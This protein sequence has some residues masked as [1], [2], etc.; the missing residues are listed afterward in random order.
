MRTFAFAALATLAATAALSAPASAQAVAWSTTPASCVVTRGADLVQAETAKVAFKPGKTGMAVLS[1]PVTHVR[2]GAAPST[3][4]LGGA[5]IHFQD[6]T[7]TDR[8]ASVI[9]R[10]MATSLTNGLPQTLGQFSSDQSTATGPFSVGVNISSNG[11]T[12]DFDKFAYN[13]TIIMVRS[14][15]AQTVAISAVTL[16]APFRIPP[17]V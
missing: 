8:T 13:V 16:R 11:I 15:L 7:G 6:S 2:F 3:T 17:P 1:C 12:L 10:L 5:N 4:Q 14:T 9:V